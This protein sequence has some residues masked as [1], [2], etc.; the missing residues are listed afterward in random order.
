MSQTAKT[1]PV[2]AP[3]TGAATDPR[4]A[5]HIAVRIAG[6]A[7]RRILMLIVL[8]AMVFAAVEILPGD[9]AGASAERGESAADLAARRHLLGLDR[10]LWARFAHW[11]TALPTGDLG[12]SARGQKVTELLADPLPNTLVLAMTAFAITVVLSLLLGCWAA[13]RPGRPTDRI[14]SHTSTAA[15]AVPEFVVSAAL[16]LVLSLWTG[17]LPAVTVTGG[18]G[19]PASWTMLIM[20]VLALVIPQAGWNTRVVRGALADQASTPHVEAAHLDGLP[21][22]HVLLRHQLPGAVPAIATGMATS[23]GLLFGG[24]VVVETLFNYPG[25]GSVLAGAV[26]A[27]DTPLIAGVVICA[28]AVVSLVLLAADLIRY[29]VLGARA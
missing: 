18:D 13:A 2:A 25:I 29:A 9:A 27:R 14:I 1:G 17:W 6:T 3:G 8:L 19:K 20:P 10:P 4:R 16:L 15:F 5:A 22:H 12:T 24:A 23:T 11:M 7:G 28:G 26:A 21:L